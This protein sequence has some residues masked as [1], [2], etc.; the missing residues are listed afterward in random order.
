[1]DTISFIVPVFNAEKYLP[2]CL[3][4][5][6]QQTAGNWEAILIDDGSP[7]GSG[8]ICDEYAQRDSRF[9]VVHL[10]NHGVAA[11][12]LTGFRQSTGTYISFLDSDDWLEPGFL[13]TVN[14]MQAKRKAEVV[15]V[16]KV[17]SDK[18]PEETKNYFYA[19]G[20]YNRKR[21]REKIY[22]TLLAN[23]KRAMSEI[24]GS[25]WG[26]VFRRELLADN[27]PYVDTTLSM[28]EDQVWLWPTLLQAE[29]ITFGSEVLYH[30]RQAVG[31]A[32]QRYHADLYRNYSGV[33]AILRRVNV[34]KWQ[35][36]QYDFSMQIDLMQVQFAIN[37]IDNE[38]FSSSLN[39]PHVYHEIKALSKES[40]LQSI[41]NKVS[42]KAFGRRKI[43]LYL[44]RRKW[45]G[46]LLFLQ[47]VNRKLR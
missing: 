3:D 6:L 24:T 42:E 35:Y 22:P 17:D 5:V 38:F 9:Q 23:P 8:G 18:R 2:A 7:D 11:A 31:Q 21:L 37:C 36:S 40:E 33:I 30:Y 20:F 4:S 43:W 29:N 12:R 47:V 32:T 16:K 41:L 28:G 45:I 15:I 13:M 39:W 1:M 34:E 14:E 19:P 44:L 25:L 46:L 27:I 10:Q 26:K